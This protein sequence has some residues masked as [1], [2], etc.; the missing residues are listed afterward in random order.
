M[1]VSTY[2][3]RGNNFLF[4]NYLKHVDIY[5]CVRCD[6]IANLDHHLPNATEV[7]LVGDLI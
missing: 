2:N 1:R 5:T 7:V 4:K 6:L 3:G